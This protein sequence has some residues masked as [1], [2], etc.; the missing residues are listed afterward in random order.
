MPV[1]TVGRN[2]NYF[3]YVSDD[4]STYNMKADQV[5]GN[6]AASGGTAASAPRSYGRASRRRQ[7]RRATYRDPTSFRTFSGPVFTSA[8]YAALVVGTATITRYFP[9]AETG[10][11]YTLVKKTPEKLPTSVV[12]RQDGQDTLAT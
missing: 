8:A 12:G 10:V 9:G 5:W 6:L 3:N 2:F 4:G 7:P 1:T 11:V